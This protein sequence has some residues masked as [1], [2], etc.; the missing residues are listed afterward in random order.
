M[1]PNT[2]VPDPQPVYIT[3]GELTE[4]IQSMEM[5]ISLSVQHQF[6]EL[7]AAG[8]DLFR[9]LSDMQRQMDTIANAVRTL[10]NRCDGNMLL[11][12]QCRVSA[13]RGH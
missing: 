4:R 5:R 6:E 3:T 12:G 2:P 11:N 8:T 7:D 13:F 10:E 1:T 9:T